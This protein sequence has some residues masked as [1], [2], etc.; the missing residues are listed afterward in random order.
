MTEVLLKELNKSDLDWILANS[1]PREIAAGTVI[2]RESPRFDTVDILIEG[3]FV[4]TVSQPQSNTN[5][6][7][8]NRLA[9]ALAAIEGTDNPSIELFQLS[10]GEIVGQIPLVGVRPE[11]TSL[12]AMKRSLL[13][14]IPRQALANKLA[15]DIGFAARFYRAIAIMF[16][17][18]LEKTIVKLGSRKLVTNQTVPDVLFI[19]GEL[20]DS[21][22]DW[23]VN[24]GSRQK[25]SADALVLEQGCPIDAIQ[26]LLNGKMAMTFSEGGRNPLNKLFASFSELNLTEIEIG[27]LSKGEIIGE[28]P[29]LDG[30]L[31]AFSVKAIDDCLVLSVARQHFA[32]KLQQDY[33]FASRFYRVISTLLADRLQELVGRFGYGR[34]FHRQNEPL[35]QQIRYEDELSFDFLDRMTLAGARF[36]WILEHSR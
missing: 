28:T 32:S 18:R 19:L 22:V 11:A 10:I 30:R 31:P 15:Q 12:K 9:R 25:I 24:T 36:D 35:K 23:L 21:D 2:N 7:K 27:R 20:H 16:A 1:H 33:G 26:I 3:N 5:E 6:G 17:D 14:S 34:R 8:V 13:Q 4:T 29:F